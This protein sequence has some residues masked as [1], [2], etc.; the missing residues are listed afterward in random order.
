LPDQPATQRERT[1]I[2]MSSVMKAIIPAAGKG[3]RFLPATKSQPKEM[4][5]IVDTP[6]MQ[7]VVEEAVASGLEDILIVTGRDKRSIEDHFDYHPELEGALQKAEKNSLWHQVREIADLANLYFIRQKQALGLG[8]ALLTGRQH[9][10]AEPFA[11]LLGDTIM[12]N[13]GAGEPCSKQLI[14]AFERIRKPIIAVEKVDPAKTGRYGIIDGEE[15]QPGLFKLRSLIEKPAP[16]EAPS[17]LAIAGRYVLT[18]DIF[19]Y[20]ETAERQRDGEIGLTPALNHMADRG[21]LYALLFTG[22]RFDIGNRLDF[23]LTTIEFA[24]RRPDIGA[25]V[26]EH[27]ERIAQ[28]IKEKSS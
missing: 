24:I 22:K 12:A 13:G 5:P 16:E 7:Y 28:E 21:E 19:D 25:E 6:V 17:N 11:V 14:S 1:P 18:P 27:I 8:D 20:I 9:I 4:L 23:V 10:G 26:R 15:V 3:T 2:R